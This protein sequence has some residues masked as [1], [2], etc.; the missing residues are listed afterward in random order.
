MRYGHIFSTKFILFIFILSSFS[1]FMFYGFNVLCMYSVCCLCGVMN[2][3]NRRT[4]GR[5]SADVINTH[6]AAS[7]LTSRL[8]SCREN[9]LPSALWCYYY[10]YRWLGQNGGKM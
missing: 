5:G 3:N 4:D 10:V 7:R 6:I 2:D 1:L 8:R 9:L